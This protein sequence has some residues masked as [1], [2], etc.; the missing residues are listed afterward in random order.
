M[1]SLIALCTLVIRKVH[2]Y[3]KSEFHLISLLTFHLRTRKVFI[4]LNLIKFRLINCGNMKDNEGQTREMDSKKKKKKDLMGE[5]WSSLHISLCSVVGKALATDPELTTDDSHKLSGCFTSRVGFFLTRIHAVP[6]LGLS[7]WQG[8]MSN[9]MP[10]SD[11]F[12][13]L[14]FLANTDRL[15][16]QRSFTGITSISLV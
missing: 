1:I 16:I 2:S 3:G 10:K 13:L 11:S 15:M 5:T 14:C 6:S 4:S 8:L 7:P 12:K 9:S